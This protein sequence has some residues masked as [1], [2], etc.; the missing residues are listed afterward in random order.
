MRPAAVVVRIRDNKGRAALH[1]KPRRAGNFAAAAEGVVS[2][3]HVD[4]A[5]RDCGIDRHDAGAA[6]NWR[7][8]AGGGE[9]DVVARDELVQRIV[10]GVEPIGRSAGVVP[11]GGVAPDPGQVSRHADDVQIDLVGRGVVDELDDLPA[12]EDARV[13]QCKRACRE[14]GDAAIAEQRVAAGAGGLD[15]SAI[16]DHVDKDGR[17]ASEGDI[18]SHAYLV[19]DV[20]A[21][22]CVGAGNIEVAGAA[23]VDGQG[24]QRQG[25]DVACGG[26]VARRKLALALRVTVPPLVIDPVPARVAPAA[27]E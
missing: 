24:G 25:A 1:D 19:V 14:A 9:S 4:R 15:C 23:A 3:R 12:V 8:G 6:D 21:R 20:R 5:G 2:A 13:S 10:V 26:V 27:I 11:R 18:A 16:S 17:R 22:N 7:S